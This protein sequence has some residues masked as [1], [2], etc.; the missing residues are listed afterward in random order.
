MIPNAP[1][2]TDTQP[3]DDAHMAERIA[4]DALAGRQRKIR[5]EALI[6]A[7]T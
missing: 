4:D 3:L 5:P 1:A 7:S 6:N 2:T